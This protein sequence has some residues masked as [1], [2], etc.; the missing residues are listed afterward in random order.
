MNG[1]RRHFQS[2]LT[3]Q[4]PCNIANIETYKISSNLSVP[5]NG[6]MA[7]Q[8]NNCC[9]MCSTTELSV[10]SN[11]AMALQPPLLK[12]VNPLSQTFSPL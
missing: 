5:S 4:W 11:G 6:A 1:Q 12:G 8:H 7:L 9:Q 2:P 3:G 10:P